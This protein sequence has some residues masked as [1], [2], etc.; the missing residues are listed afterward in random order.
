MVHPG[1]SADEQFGHFAGVQPGQAA[2]VQACQV[3]VVQPG[4]TIVV[5][6]GQI[7]GILEH[8]AGTVGT[9]G[10][11]AGLGCTVLAGRAAWAGWTAAAELGT[12]TE[13][14]K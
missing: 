6:P 8:S 11:T 7:V 14:V 13:P 3:A 5:H 10:R 12:G 9:G 4:Q 2:A 1:Q